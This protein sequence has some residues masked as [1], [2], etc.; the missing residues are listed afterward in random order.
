MVESRTSSRSSDAG[1]V[2]ATRCSDT[3]RPLASVRRPTWP[4]ARDCACADSRDT[5]RTIPLTTAVPT[6]RA[7][8]S[9]G[10]VEVL[11]D[12]VG[13]DEPA[14]RDGH[15]DRRRTAPRRRPSPSRSPPRCVGGT[16][17]STQG[18]AHAPET[19]TTTVAS[20]ASTEE[21]AGARRSLQGHGL[22]RPPHG[23]GHEGEP[24]RDH[25]AVGLRELLPA[26]HEPDDQ[27]PP[28]GTERRAVA[29]LRPAPSA[30]RA[31]STLDPVPRGG[32]VGSASLD[33]RVA[34]LGPIDVVRTPPVL[35]FARAFG[36]GRA[37]HQRRLP[38]GACAVSLGDA[39]AVSR[40]G[41]AATVP[42]P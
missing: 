42:Q 40:S 5:L 18:D 39:A 26:E 23:D 2:W 11:A 34:E 7:A 14:D 41:V 36:V 13:A 19:S 17:A 25:P 24:G 9:N 12:V 35:A 22:Q 28:S 30:A 38:P 6:S 15:H 33:Q 32:A 16:S 8:S 1:R 27:V 29:A 21:P 4:S 10:Q 31:R 37:G 20:T 3:R